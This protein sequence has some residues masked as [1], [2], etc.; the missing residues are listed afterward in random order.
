MNELIET[1][2]EAREDLPGDQFEKL[3]QA[4]LG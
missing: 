3:V 4:A 2:A 1:T